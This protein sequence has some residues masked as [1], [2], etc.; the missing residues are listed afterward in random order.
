MVWPYSPELLQEFLIH[1]N[2]LRLS[3]QFT[4]EIESDSAIAF[5][6]VVFR[7]ETTLATKVYRKPTHIV[8]YLKFKSNHPPHVKRGLFQSLHNKLPPYAKNDKIVLRLHYEPSAAVC[9]RELS[10]TPTAN[11]Y[12]PLV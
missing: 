8:R 12:K 5:L 3:T 1:V 11:S 2:S 10:R 4:M 7:E 6:D 9:Y